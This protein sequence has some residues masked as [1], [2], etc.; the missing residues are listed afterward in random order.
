MKESLG[1]ISQGDILYL[2]SGIRP[3][4]ILLNQRLGMEAMSPSSKRCRQEALGMS[5]HAHIRT[6]GGGGA[7][8][9]SSYFNWSI[10]IKYVPK[11]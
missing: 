1:L 9:F 2:L 8:V 5:F 7:Q 6:G 3:S 10:H 11:K 4:E